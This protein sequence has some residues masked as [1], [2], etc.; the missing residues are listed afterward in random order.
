MHRGLRPSAE[1][2]VDGDARRDGVV[3]LKFG[4]SLLDG[5]AGYRVAVGEIQC[6]CY[7]FQDPQCLFR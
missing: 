6:A 1:R 3:V 2:R 5:A 7:L 4:S